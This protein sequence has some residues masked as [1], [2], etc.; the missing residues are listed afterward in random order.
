MIFFKCITILTELK[1]EE[2]SIEK[3][4]RYTLNFLSL[5]R[6]PYTAYTITPAG[7]HGRKCEDS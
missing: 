4:I 2:M 6:N 7:N 5:R 1:N 3:L